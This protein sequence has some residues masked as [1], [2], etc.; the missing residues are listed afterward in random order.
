MSE[1]KTNN[2]CPSFYKEEIKH[3]KKLSRFSKLVRKISTI[4][5]GSKR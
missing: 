1:I 2:G 4:L 3:S 5:Y